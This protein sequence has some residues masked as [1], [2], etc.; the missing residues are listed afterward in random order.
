VPLSAGYPILDDLSLQQWSNTFR[1]NIDGYF[2]MIRAALPHLQPGAAIINTGSI[3]GLEG[4][5]D[6]V[7]YASTKGAI[8][9]MTK[10]LAKKLAVMPILGGDTVA[11]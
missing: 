1:T 10:S 6:L 8:H 4:N 2:F 3:T 5:A 7:D 11:G 9:A